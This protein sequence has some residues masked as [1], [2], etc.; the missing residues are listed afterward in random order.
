MERKKAIERKNNAF[1]DWQAKFRT[2]ELNSFLAGV[3]DLH[4]IQHDVK[5]ALQ[6]KRKEKVG[7][8]QAHITF[9]SVDQTVRSVIP[10]SSVITSDGNDSSAI[11]RTD[12]DKVGRTTATFEE[13]EEGT[14]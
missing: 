6:L 4:I 2:A 7:F 8:I 3:L 13:M 12:R 5:N 9:M 10:S 11:S 14:D 1:C